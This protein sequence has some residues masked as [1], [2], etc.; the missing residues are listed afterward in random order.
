MMR[1]GLVA[2][3]ISALIIACEATAP[4]TTAPTTVGQ[5]SST[6]VPS[7]SLIEQM[8]PTPTATPLPP[9]ASFSVDV[10]SGGAPLTVNFSNVSN[11]PTTSREWD[12]S[13]GP[14]AYCGRR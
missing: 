7:P 6:E 3:L 1:Y 13:R 14:L 10:N 2:I 12:F 4:T 11:G 5:R 9:S 8:A